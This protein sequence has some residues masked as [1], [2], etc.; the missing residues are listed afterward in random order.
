MAGITQPLH[1]HL[2]RHQM[3]TYLSANCTLE[4][5]LVASHPKIYLAKRAAAKAQ[6]LFILSDSD[7]ARTAEVTHRTIR[8]LVSKPDEHCGNLE[9]PR[10]RQPL[11]AIWPE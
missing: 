2:F 3:L 11:F 1:P 9:C 10:N 8:C 5:R 4:H 7:L 6:R